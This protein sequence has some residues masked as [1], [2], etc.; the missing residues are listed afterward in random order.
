[1][2]DAR[3][4]HPLSVEMGYNIEAKQIAENIRHII[5]H[6]EHAGF[7]AEKNGN[8][9]GWAHVFIALRLASKPFAEI[10]GLVFCQN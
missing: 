4:V 1:M 8:I 6:P 9:L 7:V 10:G 5:D 2:E 3:Q